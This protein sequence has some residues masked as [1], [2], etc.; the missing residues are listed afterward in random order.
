MDSPHFDIVAR[1]AGPVSNDRLRLMTQ[2]M[3]TD[4]FHLSVHTEK[5]DIPVFALIVAKDGPKQL[6]S[7]SAPNDPPHADFDQKNT[8]GGRHW[9][10]HNEPIGAVGGII[11][12]GLERPIV[13]M[14]GMAGKF[15]YTFISPLWNRD[16]GPLG[17]FTIANVFPELQRQ[18]GLRI[19]A[20]TA[21]ADVLV[22]DHADKLP[23]AN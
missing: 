8:E 17:D 12:N 11:S 15:D 19:E 6:H 23:T 2:S 3:L 18:L 20:R 22:I 5:R 14:T 4:R 7:P 13:D 21:P 1:A 10:F 9:L 16:E